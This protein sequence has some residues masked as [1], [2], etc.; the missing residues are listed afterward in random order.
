M[1]VKPKY[2]VSMI[3]K[4]GLQVQQPLADDGELE[5]FKSVAVHGGSIQ[6]KFA[7][8]F[9]EENEVKQYTVATAKDANTIVKAPAGADKFIK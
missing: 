9:L 7:T 6:N 4:T 3:L 1:A 5:D 2:L 8:L